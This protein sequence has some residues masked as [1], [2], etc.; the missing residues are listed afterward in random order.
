LQE[1]AIAL[2][3]GFVIRIL[4]LPGGGGFDTAE[5]HIADGGATN[6][7]GAVGDFDAGA[8]GASYGGEAGVNF[9][10]AEV[11]FGAFDPI[12]GAGAGVAF[13]AEV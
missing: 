6:L 9:G 7:H 12:F 11:V 4:G 5:A 3:C 2:V 13:F 10:E 1:Y 8:G